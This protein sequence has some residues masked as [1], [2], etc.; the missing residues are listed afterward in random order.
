MPEAVVVEPSLPHVARALLEHRM[1]AC[2]TVL[3]GL[4]PVG[5]GPGYSLEEVEPS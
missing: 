4:G 5:I 3:G 1:M 2:G